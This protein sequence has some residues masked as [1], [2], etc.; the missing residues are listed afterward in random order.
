VKRSFIRSAG[1]FLL[2]AALASLVFHPSSQTKVKA[3]GAALS[4]SPESGSFAVGKSFSVKVILA[5][6][7]GA[8]VNAAD[9]TVSFDSSIM[10]VS[11]VTKEGSVF[12]LWTSEPTYS[13]SN[14]T[15][16]FSGGS[17]S[18]YTRSGGTVVAITFN[19]KKAGTG[20]LSFSS[21]S[22]LAADGQ[23]T[24]VLSETKKA[25]FTITAAAAPEPKPVEKPKEE[26]AQ[27]P[28]GSSEPGT[29]NLGVE[30]T[31]PTHPDPEK[32]YNNRN[33]EIRWKLP[34]DVKGVSIS[35]N[36]QPTGNPPTASEGLIESKRF[37]DVGDGVSYVHFRIQA[38]SGSWS[39]TINR[40]VQVDTTPPDPLDIE[41][42]QAD[43][44]LSP[45]LVLRTGDRTSG[46]DRYEI[47]VGDRDV[48]VIP[49]DRLTD[50]TYQVEPLLPGRQKVTVKALDRANNGVEASK[51]FEI[52]GL[53][54]AKILGSPG[55]L[56][57]R[58]FV[59]VEGIADRN[60][61]VVIR[62]E[63]GSKIV[64]EESVRADDE[65]KW[66]YVHRKHLKPGD[67]SVSAKM[68]TRAGAESNY[69]EK[70]GLTVNGAPFVE[71]YG[72]ALVM[73]LFFALAGLAYLIWRDRREFERKAD[74]VRRETEEIRMKNEAVFT[75]LA[76]EAEEKM[77]LLDEA[78]ATKLG[79]EKMTP[80]D[81]LEKF[82]DAFDIS[83]DTIAKEIEDVEK[84]LE[85]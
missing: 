72:L 9:G 59:I 23:G 32:W 43:R 62:L 54:A 50:N 48:H 82:K 52:E 22:V 67:Y 25:N 31:S 41:V 4:F 69:G 27:T 35:L 63:T 8:G 39:Q 70:I 76:E 73:L 29:L 53:S 77:Q 81:V 12:N 21:A 28:V 13:N 19:A 49:V 1:T 75:A 36:N 85:E 20:Q 14:G 33:P 79:L 16:T 83:H 51:E 5:S 80:V 3:A 10:T 44:N 84:A 18:A 78:T 30:L 45:K 65:G 38:Q 58:E 46:L 57:E 64:G 71:K 11:S 61:K 15:I 42:Q 2:L 40:K 68:I 24:N 55:T 34:P 74:L 60:S 66:V 37:E 7:G 17:P 47:K 6:G 26:P 56:D